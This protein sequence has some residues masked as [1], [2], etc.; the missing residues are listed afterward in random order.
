MT[1]G[2]IA[3]LRSLLRATRTLTLDG[4]PGASSQ[5]A[6]GNTAG[7]RGKPQGTEIGDCEEGTLSRTGANQGS[8]GPGKWGSELVEF[9]NT[10]TEER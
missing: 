9:Q 5:S 4:N 1:S 2:L 6:P 3:D 10:G 7:A 8:R